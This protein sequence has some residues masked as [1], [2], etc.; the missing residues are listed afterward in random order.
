MQSER[1]RAG[2]TPKI[3]WREIAGYLRVTHSNLAEGSLAR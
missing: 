1:G 3:A 2:S